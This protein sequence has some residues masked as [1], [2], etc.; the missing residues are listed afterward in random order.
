[1][2]ADCE[3]RAAPRRR[4]TW[5]FLACSAMH[6][7]RPPPRSESRPSPC[8]S[9][10]HGGA[11][12]TAL[13]TYLPADD[14][15]FIL[16]LIG[17]SGVGK[18]C[19]LLR[20][21]VRAACVFAKNWLR[22]GALL[23]PG[24]D[25]CVLWRRRTISGPTATSVRSASTSCAAPPSLPCPSALGKAGVPLTRYPLRCGR[26]ENPD[27]RARRQD[28]QAANLG[29]CGPGALPHDQQHLLPRRSRHHRRV[30]HHQPRLVQ[31][32]QALAGGDQQVRPH[33]HATP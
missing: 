30:R 8:D 22:P 4:R 21:A 19:L 13:C 28:D 9:R 10:V 16:V 12:A 20:F 5:R 27:D 2:K 31:Q 25:A 23:S 6:R 29:H 26:T 3:R 11:L 14:Y 24:A 33:A 7:A 17:D 18:S 1:M 15:L 32:R